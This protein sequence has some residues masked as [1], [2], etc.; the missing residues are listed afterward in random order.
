MDCK[1]NHP[2]VQS[3]ESSAPPLG[4]EEFSFCA[5]SAASMLSLYD[6]SV[7]AQFF[8]FRSLKATAE[9]D[10]L[11]KKMA[12]RAS[13]GFK[14]APRD[15]L[16]GLALSLFS[17]ILRRKVDNAYTQAYGDF[18]KRKSTFDLNKAIRARRA[19]RRKDNGVG[20]S[21]NLNFLLLKVARDSEIFFPDGVP[22]VAWSRT[23]SRRRLGFYDDGLNQVVVSKLFDSSKVPQFV[24]EYVIFHEL[25]HA[26]HDAKYERGKTK[27][28]RVHHFE[29]RRDE[30]TFPQYD[31]AEEWIGK[32]LRYLR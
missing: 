4:N 12:L 5:Y 26:K 1:Q 15:V 31:E 23:K 21:F 25:L 11:S 7:D 22:T 16:I 3:I 17:K 8:P 30:K 32:N 13:D 14:C 2:I 18:M 6:Y 28:C 19:I 20:E 24:I 29:F 9:L 27:Q 10:R